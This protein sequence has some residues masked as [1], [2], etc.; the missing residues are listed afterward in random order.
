[1]KI[2]NNNL[3]AIALT[4]ILTSTAVLVAMPMTSAHTPPW[5][6][7]TY[8]YIVAS[9]DPIGIGQTVFI[10]FWLDKV[11]PTAGGIGGD[12]WTGFTVTVTK[13]NGD[14]QKLGPFISDA[15]SAAW[16]LYPVDQ[17]GKYTFNFN[18]PGQVASLYHPVSGIPGPTGPMAFG[19]DAYVNDTYMPS[20]ASTTLTV[21]QSSVAVPPAYPLP[22]E[23]WTR[24]IEGQNT[25]WSAI[26]SNYL[27][28]ASIND[29]VQLDGIAP[30]TP[31]I[32]WAKPLQDGGIVGV[33]YAIP[34]VSYYTGLSYEGRFASPLIMYGRLY[35]DAPLGNNAASGPYTCVDLRTGQTLWTNDAISPTF[36]Q[37]Y[38][39]ESFNQH[40]VIGDGYLV[41]TIG[42]ASFFGPPT[43]ATWIIYDARTGNWLFNI[44]GV[45]S[46]YG[47][48]FLGGY[49]SGAN[50]PSGEALIYSL[51]P[52]L[53]WLAMWN[54]S[55]GASTPLVA[56]PGNI[57]DSYQYRP[58]GKNADMS[59]AYT[60]NAT[61]SAN[62]PPGSSI[63][64]AIPDDLIIGSTPMT[65]FVS[66]GTPDPFTV[67]AINLKPSRGPIGQLLWQKSY[68]APAGNLTRAFGPVDPVSR[69]WTM[70]DKETMQ[71][72]G[73][74]LDNGEQLWGPVGDFKDFQYYGTVSHPP[75][76]GYAAYGKLFVGGYGGELVAFDLKTGSQLWKYSNTYSG[77]ETPWGLYPLFV[78][79]IADGKVYCY[80][81]E[82]SPNAPPYKGSRLRCIDATTGEEKWTLMSWYAIG[83]FGEEGMPIAD[84]FISYLNVYDM[85]IYTIGKGPSATTATAEPKVVSQ[86]SS[87]VIEGSVTDQS[88]GAKGTPAMS[89]QSMGPWMEYVY[90]QKPKPTDA[91]GVQVK[92]TAI[93]PNG[94]TI[95]IGTVTS[96]TRG[97]FSYL[98]TPSNVGKYTVV[99]SFE[100]SG[101]YWP[102]SAETAVGVSQ[103]P[104]P[105]ITAPPT[106]TPSP[107][108]PPA[109]ATPTPPP[110]VV[111]TPPSSQGI[112]T[113]VY[114]AVAAAVI[115]V[116]IAAV[117]IFLR[118][119]K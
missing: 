60:W 44:T 50:G 7:P 62:L 87:I 67:W 43:P 86:G 65:S 92:L 22:T 79:G 41:Q 8:A 91:V 53:K 54:S 97:M 3:I 26:A 21:Q 73:F 55:A 101:S 116:A 12:R 107:T 37:L 94:N 76:P 24:P 32:M 34:S 84:G 11:P 36:G 78:A 82:H 112:G 100:G 17:V 90:M 106:S 61:I 51:A 5:T 70:T 110:S 57:T 52:N 23:Y 45:P 38:L 25:E 95:D 49:G 119:R 108:S 111:P 72:L 42:G 83:S 15:T 104:S 96:D 16:T 56:T 27:R 109:T 58:I 47:A 46:G 14:T 99:A 2:K 89:D 93:D 102:S 69:V 19:L 75:A 30:N 33:N 98:W 48:G 105:S 114:I 40:G 103:A 13:P 81:S 28:G 10:V 80:T 39:Y 31:H 71:W 85:R 77:T 9:P 113:E 6:I 64:R 118:R 35:Y 66:F 18:F 74:S 63:L 59:K 29:K 20:S 117:A 4:L 115:I 68:A 88:A 1:M